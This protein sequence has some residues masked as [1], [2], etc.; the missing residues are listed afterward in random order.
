MSD[1]GL[2]RYAPLAGVLFAVL[3][4]VAFLIV[5]DTPDTDAS[6][7]KVFAFWKDHDSEGMVS[8]IVGALAALALAW[9]AGSLRAHLATAER[10][11]SRLSNVAFGGGLIAATGLFIALNLQF[12]IADTVGD[13]PPIVTQTMFVISDDFFFPI[14]GGLALM[15]IAAGLVGVRAGALPAWLAWSGI[16][17]A[18][19]GLVL[20]FP[21]VLLVLLW[22]AVAGIWLF[23]RPGVE[24]APPATPAV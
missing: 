7:A 17:L 18:V 4:V 22:E 6:T 15:L 16:V 10:P 3:T 8:S 24:P 14:V 5:G 11:P 2:A 9:F 20:P 21:V 13:V 23:L 1:T 19:A 12:A